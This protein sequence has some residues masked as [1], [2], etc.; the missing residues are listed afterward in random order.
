MSKTVERSLFE[1]KTLAYR[2][3]IY[4]THWNKQLLRVGLLGLKQEIKVIDQVVEK[5]KPAKGI[6]GP[7]PKK[8]EL[9]KKALEFGKGK[10]EELKYHLNAILA[11]DLWGAFETY[12][13]MLFE[14]LFLK[15]PELLISDEKISVA[16]AVKN[17]DELI[18]YLIE[19]QV[20]NIGHF[21]VID[22]IKFNERK[23]KFKYTSSQVSK[24][25]DMYLVRNIVAHNTG[26]V[27]P[28]YITQ[29]PPTIKAIKNEIRLTDA[30]LRYI[31][32]NIE[33]CVIRVEKHVIKKFYN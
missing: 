1:G 30:Y 27:R 19:R 23:L 11:V 21:S 8:Y 5:L 13:T 2:R 29:L 15:K 10:Y 6:P 3:F 24:L 25:T 32:K 7:R 14:E 33:A 31:A 9:M 16:E 22:L 17:R 12:N 4:R 20:D 18:Q 26:L 28:S